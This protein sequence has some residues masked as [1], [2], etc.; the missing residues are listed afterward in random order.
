MSQVSQTNKNGHFTDLEVSQKC[1]Q[2][3]TSVTKENMTYKGGKNGSGVYQA[4]INLMPPHKVYVE[5]FLGGGA[6]LRTKRPAKFNFG[7]EI[8]ES[9][10][11]TLWPPTDE[12]L[13]IQ[14]DAV[15]WLSTLKTASTLVYCDPP[16][17]MDVRSS[18][19]KIYDS[20]FYSVEDHT[21]LLDVLLQLNCMVM[22]SGY[23]SDLYNE[24]L[25]EWRKVQFQGISRGGPRT[26]TVWLNF[27]EPAELHDYRFLGKNRRERQDIK[28]QKER[29]INRLE[30]MPPTKRYAML[31]AIDSYKASMS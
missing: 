15:R 16:Y 6:I 13:V 20:E 24:K 2:S 26:E 31:S 21:R 8:D 23:D 18:K 9:V 27:A 11:R 22:I 30:N 28:R 19:Q 14:D 7:I 25:K 12:Y 29:W 10:I 4:I 1:H 3:V 5:A 17:L